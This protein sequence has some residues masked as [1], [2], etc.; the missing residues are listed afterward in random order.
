[1]S[2]PGFFLI[3]LVLFFLLAAVAG[4]INA[5]REEAAFREKLRSSYGGPP[6]KKY[7]PEQ[8]ARIPRY[9]EKHRDAASWPVD[10]ITAVDLDLWSLY[11]RINYC[12]SAAGEEVL[13]H[14]LRTPLYE[15][16]QLAKREEE[17]S[18]LSVNG[19]ARLD[20]QAAFHTLGGS[21]K[22]S[23]YDYLDTLKLIDR[24]SNLPHYLGVLAIIAAAALMPFQFAA[25]FILLLAVI[26]WQIISYYRAKNESD[27]YLST[28]SYIL[29]LNGCAQ[30][31]KSILEREDELPEPSKERLTTLD[32][33]MSSL[34]DFRKGASVL[35]SSSRMSG[36]GNPADLI[37]DYIRMLLHVDLIKFNQMVREAGKRSDEIDRLITALGELEALISIV[38]YR[39]SLD[40][41][42]DNTWCVPAFHEDKQ[43]TVREL[44]HVLIEEGAVPNSIS[45]TRDV[46]L[47]GSNASGKSTWLKALGLAAVMAQTVHTVTAASYESFFCRTYSSMALQDDLQAGES[48]YIVEI[49]ALGRILQ[50]AEEEQAPVILCFIDE[51]LRGTNTIERIAASAQIL[52]YF[53]GKR[54]LLFAATHDTELTTLLEGLYDNYHFEGTL[55]EEDVHFDY[56][57]KEGPSV[58]RNAIGL[59][60][61]FSYDPEITKRAEAMAAHFIRTGEWVADPAEAGS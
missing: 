39:A 10:D 49:R 46:L 53:A 19:Q 6:M 31:I 59:L 2:D 17:L 28:F 42:D 54:A 60:R 23:V 11:A 56:L 20:L 34:K 22:Y 32:H 21:G 3:G 4:I 47:T 44:R 16:K 58:T 8:I 24:K 55:T 37:A 35:M 26:L 13:Y 25:G 51:V 1:M 33:C 15:K 18:W 61:R 57:L 12:L 52:R 29:R 9:F 27:A 40:R 41:I 38:C 36:S 5:R 45:V 14:L 7:S 50:A 43:L 30:R 48:Y